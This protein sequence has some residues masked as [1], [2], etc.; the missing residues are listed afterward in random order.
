M[1]LRGALSEREMH[2]ICA[3]GAEIGLSDR[4][5]IQVLRK[6]E[7]EA[8][9]REAAE[10]N[11]HLTVDEE[12]LLTATKI[13]LGEPYPRPVRMSAHVHAERIRLQVI[14]DYLAEQRE[15]YPE[16]YRREAPTAS[17]EEVERL[18]TMPYREYL[19]SDHWDRT[20]KACYAAAA[21]RC[22]LCY[23]DG[24]IH[25]HH[26]TYERRGCE[27]PSDVIALCDPCHAKFHD[28]LP[29]EPR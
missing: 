2:E 26:R 28:K 8:L 29:K 25:A 22:Q 5:I 18:R 21:Y 6:R 7:R 19:Q 12:S 24:E 16:R 15:A 14:W 23:S 3:R 27:L 10:R 4:A 9:E 20:R 1:A 17:P 11:A 13:L